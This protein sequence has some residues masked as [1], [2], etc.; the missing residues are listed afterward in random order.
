MKALFTMIWLFPI[1][2]MIHDFEE[3][4]MINVWQKKNEQ[5]IQSRKGKYIPYNFKGSTAS[6]AFAVALEFIVISTLTIISYL[7]GSFLAW[8]GLFVAF[9]LHL[10]FHVVINISFKKYVPG[11]VTSIIFIPLCFYMAYK[12]KTD[13]L[14]NHN[15]FTI[16]FCVLISVLLMLS[17]VYGLHKSVKY[18]N[19]WLERY[20]SNPSLSEAQ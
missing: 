1:L 17:I 8:F 13:I 19:L 10:L 5:Y 9:T 7:L 14:L 16:L 15:I 18:F 4:L 11:V 12:V 6:I 3:I 20:K 2:F